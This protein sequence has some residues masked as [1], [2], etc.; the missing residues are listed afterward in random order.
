M[1]PPCDRLKI[2]L[3]IVKA[4]TTDNSSSDT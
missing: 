3:A 1:G 2:E 4:L